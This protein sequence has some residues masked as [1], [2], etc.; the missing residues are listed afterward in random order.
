MK[1]NKM[2]IGCI[3]CAFCP[4]PIGYGL[5]RYIAKVAH[6]VWGTPRHTYGLVSRGQLILKDGKGQ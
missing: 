5:K 6:G 1:A 2:E 4:T 3:G